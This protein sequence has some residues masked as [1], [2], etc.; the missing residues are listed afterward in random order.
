MD[1]VTLDKGGRPA[2]TS[3][4]KL[5]A[6]A[7]KLFI[8]KGFEQTSVEDIASAV[9]VSRRTFFRYF[10]TK[11][12][13]VWF[14]CDA[15]IGRLNT[16]LAADEGIL[17]PREVVETA[18][19]GA[20]SYRPADEAWARHRAQ[21][22]LTVPAVHTQAAL[23]YRRIHEFVIEFLARRGIVPEDEMF[24]LTFAHGTTAAIMAA[25]ELWIAHPETT[26]AQCLRCTI[27]LLVPVD[28]S[29]DRT[30][31]PSFPPTAASVG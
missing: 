6:S 26:L 31:A 24:A 3:A 25:H 29:T 27:R 8:A 13:V 28:P 2:I 16:Y 10:P 15:E 30:V 18:I 17:P 5:A 9:G 14:E 1:H 22:V 7:H 12:D 4:R 19:I 11:A 21:L 23:R 20:L